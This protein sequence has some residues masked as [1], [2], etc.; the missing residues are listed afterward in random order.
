MVSD[1]SYINAANSDS[2]IARCTTGLG[3][4]GTDNDELGEWYFD[5]DAIMNGECNES[6]AIQSNGASINDYVGVID[7]LQCGTFSTNM[8]GIY[9][10]T[11]MANLE[12]EQSMRLAVYF[13]GRS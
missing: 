6:N 5:G 12:M 4:E 8:E 10:C 9:T 3:P 1:Y 2:L 13:S 7:L 11:V